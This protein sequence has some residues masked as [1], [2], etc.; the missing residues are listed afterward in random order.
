LICP[1][2]KRIVFLAGEGVKELTEVLRYQEDGS[3]T[4]YTR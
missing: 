3:E 2:Q 4:H 1:F